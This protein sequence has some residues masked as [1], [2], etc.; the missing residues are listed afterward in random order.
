MAGQH[1]FSF[2]IVPTADDPNKFRLMLLKDGHWIDSPLYPYGSLVE[3]E[4]AGQQAV[5]QLAADWIFG[6]GMLKP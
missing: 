1:P 6:S 4:E 5:D 2:K 3:A